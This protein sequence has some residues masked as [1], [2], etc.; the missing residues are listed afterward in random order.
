MLDHVES[1]LVKS[2]FG[3][4]DY[5]PLIDPVYS[6]SDILVNAF[7]HRPAY[8]GPVHCKYIQGLY[9]INGTG[10]RWAVGCCRVV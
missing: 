10:V 6:I 3:N 5:L 1:S 4:C 2:P 8:G 9:R 7:I